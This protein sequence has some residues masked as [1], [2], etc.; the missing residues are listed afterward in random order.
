M[1]IVT[2]HKGFVGS[3]LYQKVPNAIGIGAEEA[4]LFLNNFTDWKNVECVYHMG[5]IS[6]TTETDIAKIYECNINFTILLFQKCIEYQIPIKY[7]SSASVYGNNYPNIN[8][9]NYYALSKATIDY[10]VQDN[11]DKFSFIQGYRFFNVYGN[12]EELKGN[13]ASPITQFRNQALNTGKIKIF[14]GSENCMRDFIYVGDICNIVLHN[15]KQSG[16]YDLGTSNPI[17]FY[18]VAELIK[19]KFGGEIVCVP[20]P[21]HLKEKYQFYTC[22]EKV[23]DY[24]FTTVENYISNF[25]L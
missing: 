24:N 13:Q 21:N 3:H 17:S 19:G 22:A 5:A 20:F 18:D 10:Y 11:L 1:N 8:P 14:E 6:S 4:F 7:A 2:G 12:N 9:L 15:E 23:F 25:L 16:I